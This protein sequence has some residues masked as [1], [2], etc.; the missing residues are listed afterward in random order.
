MSKRAAMHAST[1]QA[2]F[3]TS[4][5]AMIVVDAS[6]HIVLANPQAQR[7]FGYA[8]A[9]MSGLSVE[10]LVPANVRG[11]HHQHRARYAAKPRVRPMGIGQE[12]AGVRSDGSQFPVEIALS[13]IQT[14][15]GHFYV[16]SIRDISETQRARQALVRARYDAL[17]A[18]VGRLLLESANYNAAF[19]DIPA[20]IAN[21][22]G[23]DA[24]A[25]VFI[26]HPNKL[27]VRA[28]AELTAR[29]RDV[30]QILL[31]H[32]TFPSVSPTSE[33][34][35]VSLENL[36][37]DEAEATRS[38]LA[39]AQILDF[40]LVPLFDRGRSM[41][42]L[43][44]LVR[45]TESLDRD[46]VHMLQSIA[47]LLASTVQRSRSEEQLAHAQRLEAVGQL[48][49]GIA[50]DF[51]NLLT[52]ISGN[53][54]LLEAE[55]A[56]PGTRD[57]LASA[58]RAV[59]RGAELTRK[60]LAIARR[61][62]LNPQ[63]IGP[64]QLF[65]EL[66][67][68]LSRTLGETV[69]VEINCMADLPNVFV[70]PG[71]LDA[72]IL[73]LAINARDAMPRGGTLTIGVR[74]Q[75]VSANESGGELASGRYVV[76]SVRDTG[77]GM[78]PDV[79]PRAFEPFFTTKDA[80]RGSGLG[81]SMVYGF[82]KQSGGHVTADSRLGYGTCIEMYLP[83]VQQRAPSAATTAAVPSSNGGESILVVEDEGEVRAIAVAFLH[84]LDYVTYAAENGEQAL[85]LLRQ[86][87]DVG[88][89]FS[90]VIL[91]SGM[92]GAELAEAAQQLRPGLPTLLTS[93]YE[94]PAL[95]QDAPA[96]SERPLLRKPYRREELAAAV[97]KAID[98]PHS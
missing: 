61:Q 22:I 33:R 29:L 13:P 43:V 27:D 30:L 15:D 84:S 50:H 46:K 23:I 58:M 14:V 39:A 16:A 41:G 24:I 85:E 37:A 36:L 60:L 31:G 12:L 87:P 75:N 54:Q 19:E 78:T 94:H 17:V 8:P 80:G 88:L 62:R 92:N 5:D 81:L 52:V 21:E 11:N 4:P 86:H 63:P 45:N 20:L 68:M 28:S 9:L 6:G 69:R 71:E 76:I 55:L 64:Q 83:A 48:T 2:L 47:N 73:N 95:S 82:V 53:L 10:A 90:D 34:A 38:V 59:G 91:G 35:I 40:A 1:F 65:D 18:K 56:E 66:V 7:L 32:D 89:L 57:T 74:E 98:R 79:L 3:E 67:P 49:G 97:R 51:N 72:A 70:D 44:A 77:L 42:A 25:I 26:Q 93:G 96:S